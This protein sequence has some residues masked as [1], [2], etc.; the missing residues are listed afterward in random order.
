MPNY[1]R[2]KLALMLKPIFEE[3]AKENKAIAIEKARQE[4]PNNFNEQFYQKYDT[5]VEKVNT[6]K[7]LA[8]VAGV[9]HDTIHKVEKIEEKAPVEIKVKLSKGE[10][11]INQAYIYTITLILRKLSTEI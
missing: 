8:K 5:T 6:N 3:K 7:E 1:E 2:A 10:I 11:S 4:N 9:S